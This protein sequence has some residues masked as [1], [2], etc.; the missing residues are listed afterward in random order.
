MCA[1]PVGEQHSHESMAACNVQY[2]VDLP[3][4]FRGND[5]V[6]EQLEGFKRLLQRGKGGGRESE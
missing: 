6:F 1:K 4:L 2:V 3:M 5:E